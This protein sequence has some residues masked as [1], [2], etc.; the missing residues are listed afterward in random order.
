LD[1]GVTSALELGAGSVLRGLVRRIGREL[2]RRLPVTPIAT[3]DD[4]DAHVAAAAQADGAD[5]AASGD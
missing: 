5:S 1:M 2:E 3:P 4:I